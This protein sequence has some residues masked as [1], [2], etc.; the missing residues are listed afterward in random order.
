MPKS[1]VNPSTA[2]PHPEPT[3]EITTDELAA[4]QEIERRIPWRSTLMVHHANNVRPSLE[5]SKVGGHQA[6]SASVS[7]IITALYFHFLRAGARVST[8]PHASPIYHAAQYLLG[9]L[10]RK[11]LTTLR[12]Y[13]GLQAYP[14][15]TQA[16]D[17][18]D[19]ATGSG[20]IGS[21]P[22]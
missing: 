19:F 7:S 10:D 15:S 13:K 2:A 17:R 6:S 8:T 18:A 9:N 5:K 16:P 20:G 14:S 22:S 12:E 4:P 21:R 3:I 11:Y 1:H